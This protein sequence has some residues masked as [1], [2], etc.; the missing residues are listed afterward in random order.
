MT[1]C[2]SRYIA[3]LRWCYVPAC[4]HAT[5]KVPSK[6]LSQYFGMFSV[7]TSSTVFYCFNSWGRGE[8]FAPHLAFPCERR[9]PQ[10]LMVRSTLLRLFI[11]GPLRAKSQNP[12]FSV[13]W[14]VIFEHLFSWSLCNISFDKWYFCENS[15]VL[16]CFSWATSSLAQT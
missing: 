2:K 5:F 4:S 3:C 8:C 15:I 14:G 11:R 10:V 6:L 13:T 9:V 7:T 1:S 12:T 16:K